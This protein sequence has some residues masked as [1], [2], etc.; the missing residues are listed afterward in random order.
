MVADRGMI[1][2]ETIAELEKP[3]R[4]W[5]YILGARMRSQKEVRDEVLSRARSLPCGVRQKSIR[6]RSVAVEGQG[7]VGGGATLRSVFERG[8]G[9]QGRS[10]SRGHR[11][12]VTGEVTAGGQVVDW[13]PRLPSLYAGKSGRWVS[14]LT[15]PRSRRSRVTTASGC[16]RTNTELSSSEVALQ[17]KMLWMVE[18]WFRSCKSL[19][20]TRTIYHKRDETIRGHV[21][22]SFLALVL[23][24]E[25][26]ARLETCGQEW[27]WADVLQDLERLRVVEVASEGKRFLLRSE[28]REA[29][30][31]VFQAVGVAIP[32]VV[33]QITAREGQPAPGATPTL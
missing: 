18:H 8:R 2:K 17:Y 13:Q 16:L 15:R 33:R 25:L 11:G 22:C 10:G 12:G 28:V 31:R 6:H 24:Q 30:G 1:S 20:E 29:C 32:P 21:F 14:R 9:P 23:R 26:E 19:L 5:Q 27:E 4:D 7:S 3:E